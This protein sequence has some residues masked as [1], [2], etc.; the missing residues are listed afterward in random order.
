M[1]DTTPRVAH[2]PAV[3][4]PRW[5]VLYAVTLPQLAALAALDAWPLRYLVALGVF[6]AMAVW[7]HANRA[8]L[9]LQ[10]WCECAPERMTVRVIDSRRPEPAASPLE[11]AR[12]AVGEEELEIAAR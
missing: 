8:A 3:L 1:C 12:V 2:G 6:A 5:E 7:V 4:R 11:P 9:D 10:G